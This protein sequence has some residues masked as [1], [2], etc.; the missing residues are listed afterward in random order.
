MIPLLHQSQASIPSAVQLR[1][2][3]MHIHVLIAAPWL[4][5]PAEQLGYKRNT[6]TMCAMHGRGTGL[7]NYCQFPLKNKKNKKP[8]THAIITSRVAFSYVLFQHWLSDSGSAN[9]LSKRQ[10]NTS[11]KTGNW[12]A[13]SPQSLEAFMVRQVRLNSIQLLWDQLKTCYDTNLVT[14][15]L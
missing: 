9:L 2:K 3:H 11:M 4:G 6:W 12:S 8:P 5:Q 7:H 13:L 15:P 1:S 10:H 14:Q